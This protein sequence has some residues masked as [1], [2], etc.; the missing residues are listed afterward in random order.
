VGAQNVL[1]AAFVSGVDALS[2]GVEERLTGACDRFVAAD[3]S[4]DF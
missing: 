3:L 1:V 4:L 2:E